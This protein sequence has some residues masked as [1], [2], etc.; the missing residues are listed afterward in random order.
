MKRAE[1]N[2]ISSNHMNFNFIIMLKSLFRDW[3]FQ[4]GI[5]G[6]LLAYLPNLYLTI[7]P[8]TVAVQIISGTGGTILL[9]ISIYTKIVEAQRARLQY[10]K[11]EKEFENSKKT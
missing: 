5:W 8:F 1:L 6:A 9:I 10:K 2:F 11:E 4:M 3:V 7:E